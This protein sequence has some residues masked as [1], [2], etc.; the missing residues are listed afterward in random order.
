MGTLYFLFCWSIDFSETAK[1]S[2]MV[3]M[4][5]LPGLT[6]PLTTCHFDASDKLANRARKLLHVLL[7][8]A[9]Y[10]SCVWLFS[11]ESRV[12]FITILAGFVGSLFFQLITKY[13]LKKDLSF[14]QIGFTAILSG[15][16]F[17]PFELIGR[18]SILMGVAVLLWTIANGLLLNHEYKKSTY[19]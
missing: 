13:I 6:F 7:S 19:R 9:I 4:M 10:H 17:L 14:V 16:S 15:F 12:E 18:E 8:I 3:L 11:G 1:G 5:F 2:F